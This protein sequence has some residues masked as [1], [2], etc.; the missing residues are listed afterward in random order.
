[1]GKSLI[2][3]ESPAKIKTLKKFLGSKFVFES[4]I[5]HIRDLPKKSF[6]IDVDNEF[7]PQY[8]N[9]PDSMKGKESTTGPQKSK[10]ISK[11]DH[12][13]LSATKNSFLRMY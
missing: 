13:L 1:M 4:S 10:Q 9:M 11:Q 5:G 7:E 2:I 6:G 8:E 3:V 12:V